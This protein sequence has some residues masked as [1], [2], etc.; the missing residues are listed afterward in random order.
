MRRYQATG[1]K[2]PGQRCDLPMK[3]LDWRP[4]RGRIERHDAS[5]RDPELAA[6]G[7]PVARSCRAIAFQP[8]VRSL[9]LQLQADLGRDGAR[10]SCAV[11]K[12]VSP[13]LRQASATQGQNDICHGTGSGD[14][15]AALMAHNIGVRAQGD[16]G[17]WCRLV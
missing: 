4:R 12:R 9:L 8:Q 11:G 16:R 1:P 15:L 14:Y 7:S 5:A 10:L 17:E 2:Y 13:K 3:H 6:T